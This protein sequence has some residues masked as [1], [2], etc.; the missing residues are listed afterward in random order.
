MNS[1]IGGSTSRGTALKFLIE[2]N[3]VENIPFNFFFP[4]LNDDYGLLTE[5]VLNEP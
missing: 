1:S 3:Q 2:P 4:G 5:I